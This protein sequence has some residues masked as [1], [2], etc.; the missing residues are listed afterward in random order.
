MKFPFWFCIRCALGPNN[1][2]DIRAD[3]GGDSELNLLNHAKAVSSLGVDGRTTIPAFHAKVAAAVVGTRRFR[4]TFV[5]VASRPT[6]VKLDRSSASLEIASTA[7]GSGKL[8]R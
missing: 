6:H 7:S 8:T 2:K 3:I 1:Y 4:L 5:L